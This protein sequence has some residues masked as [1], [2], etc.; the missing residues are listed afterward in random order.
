MSKVEQSTK[1][2]LERI[3]F[4]GRTYKEYLDMFSLSEE[5]LERKKILDCPAGACSFT[6]VGNELG[7]DVTACDI[8]YYYS[9]EDLKNKGLQDIEHAMEHMEKAKSNY[10][11]DYFTD[12]DGLRKHRLSALQNCANDMKKSSERYIPVTLPSLP[13][14]NAEFDIL[15]SAHFLFLYADRL[16]YQFHIETIN[17]LLRV[18]K[19]E[20]RIFPLVDLE[21]KRYEH[22]DKIISYLA[23][24]GCTVEEMKVSYEFQTNANSMLKIK[25]GL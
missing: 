25:K 18:T 13:F 1:L 23:D 10:K 21:G 15:L 19:E 2:D 5:E 6:A 20:I 8:A 9:G 22:L 14:E 12:I 7:L 24:N 17:E 3:I 4:I 11:W 16:D